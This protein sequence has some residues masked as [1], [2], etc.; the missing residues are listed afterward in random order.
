MKKSLRRLAT[1]V[2][3]AALTVTVGVAA[4]ADPPP[5]GP[6]Y[7]PPGGVTLTSDGDNG[8]AG[9]GTWTYTDLQLDLF[10]PLMWGVHSDSL[11][12]LSMD[13]ATD[14]PGETMAFSPGESDLAAG[15]LVFAGQ[16]ELPGHGTFPTRAIIATTTAGGAALPMTPAAGAELPAHIGG[17]AV[18]GGDFKA[19]VRFEVAGVP[20]KDF[21]DAAPTT[22]E[23]AEDLHTS[24]AGAFYWVPANELPEASFDWTPETPTAGRTV[25]FTST[26]GDPDGQIEQTLWDLDGDGEFDDA[27]GDTASTVFSDPGDHEVGVQVT[28]DRG[29]VDTAT[30][31]VTVVANEPPAASFTWSPQ[32]PKALQ[33]V[34]FTS[35]STDSDGTIVGTAWDLDDDGEFDDAEGSSASTAFAEAGQYTVGVQVTDDLGAV[36]ITTQV[37]TV[38][39]CERGPVSQTLRQLGGLA[40]LEPAIRQVNCDV[41]EPLGL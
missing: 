32:S 3:G 39:S 38:T 35:T 14:G 12:Q 17:V 22:P 19:N 24:I 10:D 34:T 27:T 36:G 20:A 5:S 33:T 26:S 16:A 11:P 2:A 15:R 23:Q 4:A 31:T 7:P 6:A 28:D 1:A 21:F 25:E 18:L 13:G 41:L 29:G 40:G 30:N 37:I 8:R 9:G